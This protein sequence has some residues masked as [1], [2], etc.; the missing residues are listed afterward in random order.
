MHNLFRF[1][2]FP[3]LKRLRVGIWTTKD[4]STG[5]KNPTDISF[6]NI[7]N[8][9]LFLDTIKYFQQSLG[10]L[11][12]SLIDQEKSA[13]SIECKKFIKNDQKLTKKYL[14]CTEE[15]KWKLNYLSTG[16]GTIPYG[17]ITRYDSLDITPK[18]VSFFS[19]INFIP[20]KK[21]L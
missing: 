20:V 6:A 7:G 13:V 19:L 4:L 15:Q 12:N 14:K 2:F 17:I 5:G 9:I 21:I 10:A 3:L 11:V 18:M 1:D 8:Q 16:K